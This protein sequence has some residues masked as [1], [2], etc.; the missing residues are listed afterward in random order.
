MA[1][2]DNDPQAPSTQKNKSRK[3]PPK[4]GAAPVGRPAGGVI[5]GQVNIRA[6]MEEQSR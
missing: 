2:H 1:R 5:I 3:S 4:S 6:W